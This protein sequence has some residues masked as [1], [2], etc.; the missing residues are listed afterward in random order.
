ML[1][2]MKQAPQ[3]AVPH[4]TCTAPIVGG[5]DFVLQVFTRVPVSLQPHA[6][7]GDDCSST[8]TAF[9]VS[10]ARKRPSR[11]FAVMNLHSTP[12]GVKNL[13]SSL[14]GSLLRVS[15][16]TSDQ[17]SARSQPSKEA[18]C[19]GRTPRTR[20]RTATT[21]L[22]GHLRTLQTRPGTCRPVVSVLQINRLSQE[23]HSA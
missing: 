22:L 8:Q 18:K 12:L 21:A 6:L 19:I 14:G 7:T 20:E 23:G 5:S 3:H 13:R 11:R 10:S 1:Q 9:A 15:W 2:C 4:L 16:Q 17:Q